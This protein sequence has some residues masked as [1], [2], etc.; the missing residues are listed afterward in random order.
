MV[1]G[2]REHFRGHTHTPPGSF[3]LEIFILPICVIFFLI[4]QFG[5][6]TTLVHKIALTA[7]ILVVAYTIALTF[8]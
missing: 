6:R 2:F 8:I 3:I 1:V 4:D 5:H 7:N